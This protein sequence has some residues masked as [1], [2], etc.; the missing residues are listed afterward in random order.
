MSFSSINNAN[1]NVNKA[2]ASIYIDKLSKIDEEYRNAVNNIL[3]K[4]LLF[5]T[6]FPFGYIWVYDKRL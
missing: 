1:F 4:I 6:K 5:G 2:N 3:I